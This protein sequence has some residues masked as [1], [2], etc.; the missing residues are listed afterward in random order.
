MAE[1]RSRL[2]ALYHRPTSLQLA[3][4]FEDGI[5]QVVAD[6]LR[7]L[8]D[9]LGLCGMN[10]V[11]DLMLTDNRSEFSDEDGLGT[12]LGEIWQDPPI[13]LR[14]VPGRPKKGVCEKNRV[15]IRKLLPKGSYYRFDRLRDADCVPLISQINS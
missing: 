11:F 12:L 6:V 2:L 4:S 9:V 13:L 1:D 15:E 10:R 5:S 3:L 8:R 7:G 14:P